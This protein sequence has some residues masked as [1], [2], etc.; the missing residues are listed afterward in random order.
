MP[1]RD[2]RPAQVTGAAFEAVDDPKVFVQF[3][4]GQVVYVR[5]AASAGA[6][7]GDVA[8]YIAALPRGAA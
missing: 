8:S 2:T 3:D 1:P 6:L 7:R 4:Y 5:D